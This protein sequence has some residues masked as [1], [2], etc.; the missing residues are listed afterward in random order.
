MVY[1][2][3]MCDALVCRID[4]DVLHFT[5][6]S[7]PELTHQTRLGRKQPNSFKDNFMLPRLI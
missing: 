3:G 2:G 6:D 5:R 4:P 7:A 1:R